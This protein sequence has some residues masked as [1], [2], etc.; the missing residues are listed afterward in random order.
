MPNRPRETAQMRNI[1]RQEGEPV[2]LAL[3]R[4]CTEIGIN[5]LAERWGVSK[6]TVGY[7]MLKCGIRIEYAAVPPGHEV[8]VIPAEGEPYVV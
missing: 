3:K 4:L 8:W 2:A 1:A 5:G 6:A 7:W